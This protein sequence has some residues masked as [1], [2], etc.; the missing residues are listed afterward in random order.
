MNQPGCAPRRFSHS[1]QFSQY[2]SQSNLAKRPTSLPSKPLIPALH[3]WTTPATLELFLHLA[4]WIN[5]TFLDSDDSEPQTWYSIP[6]VD[7]ALQSTRCLLENTTW[8][9][10]ASTSVISRSEKRQVPIVWLL[11]DASGLVLDC[12]HLRCLNAGSDSLSSLP[13]DLFGVD[14][15]QISPFGWPEVELI[16]SE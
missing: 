13:M 16:C 2:G 11:A 6:S 1:L 12:L 14:H 15:V 3:L 7:E 10:P 4:H 9:R 5:P 8:M